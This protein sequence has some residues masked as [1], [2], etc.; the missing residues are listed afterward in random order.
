MAAVAQPSP[1]LH[2]AA[3]R[4]LLSTD[5]WSQSLFTAMSGLTEHLSVDE[6]ES[7]PEA[8]AGVLPAFRT[9]P[10]RL[11]FAAEIAVH[12]D[13]FEVARV[14]ADLATGA[15]DRELLL[16]AAALCGNPAVEPPLRARVA[17]ALGDDPVG[18]I[19]LDRRAAPA[20]ADEERLYHQCWP[21]ARTAPAEFPLA[22]V[23]VIDGEFRA[24]AALRFALHLVEAG[25][26]VR[27]LAAG[28][29]VPHWFGAQTVLVCRPHARTRVLSAY[30]TFPA[31]RILVEHE[32][33]PDERDTS[34]LL[35]RVSGVL[36]G[37][38]RLRLT[39]LE[40]Q[41]DIQV[42]DPAVFTA[43]AYSI[44]D[45]AFLA[46]TTR[47]SLYTLLRKGVLRP[48]SARRGPA[49]LTFRDVVAVR[50]WTYLR[51]MSGSRISSDVIESLMRFAGDAEAGAVGLSIESSSSGLEVL[52]EPQY[53]SE[54]DRAG[55]MRDDVSTERIGKLRSSSKFM[56]IGATSTGRVLVDR[57]SGW[58]DVESG[59]STLDVP[60]TEL[61]Q[62]FRPFK[63]GGGTT[64][65]LLR[66]T[67]NTRLNPTI[68]HGTPY[69]NGHRFSAKALAAVYRNGG[70]AAITETYP[71][72]SNVAI[73]GTVSIGLQ[74]LEGT[75]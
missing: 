52:A 62:V 3:L 7:L 55:H 1:G 48:L 39:A 56:Q 53:D 72:L 46:G 45:A 66:A 49:L 65:D 28:V 14:V 38:Q 6:A 32:I 17:D 10:E 43:G 18:R 51:A 42:W 20:T 25:A 13:L 57:G 15:G 70:Y 44:R 16:A 59:Q 36:P 74:L 4:A 37:R 47:S 21:G 75:R 41:L 64:V 33:P 50:T 31:A 68:L 73:E 19:R 30:P 9:D 71:E 58:Y 61:D 27:R 67:P 22:P 60:L 11:R 54:A 29:E 40:P 2:A 5:P 69:L 12:L 8:I 34:R 35:H 26:T 63:Y 24:D 23:V